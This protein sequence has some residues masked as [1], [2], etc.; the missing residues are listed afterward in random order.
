MFANF[1][2]LNLNSILKSYKKYNT[3]MNSKLQQAQNQ[4][5]SQMLCHENSSPYDLYVMILRLT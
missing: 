1:V 2:N 3:L 5:E 4:P